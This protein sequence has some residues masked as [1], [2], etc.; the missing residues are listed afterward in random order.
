[1]KKSLIFGITLLIV[2]LGFT[3]Y[4]EFIKNPLNMHDITNSGSK[5]EDVY[6]SLDVTYVAGS[7]T[8]NTKFSYH[9]MFGDGVQYIVYMDN[10]KA[11]E[12]REY[13]LDNPEKSYKITGV[14]KLIPT[15]LE[16]N[17]K[18]FV[19]EWLDNNHSHEE[20]TD[21]SHDITTDDF[22][23]YFGYVYFDNTITESIVYKIIIYVTGII[24]VVFILYY[25]NIKY[26]LL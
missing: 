14:T 5:L 19:K 21:H 6:V 15:S 13:L 16:E 4:N 2:C 25:I 23:H 22:Y 20:I 1:M 7:I 26:H 18:K 9:V 12:I 24:G 3:I 17:G 8:G 10:K 11:N